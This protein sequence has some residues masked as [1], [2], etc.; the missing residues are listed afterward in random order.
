MNKEQHLLACL[1]EECAEIIKEVNKS[2]R[3]GIDD[4]NPNDPTKVTTRT[5]L[6]NELHELLAVIQL[7]TDHGTIGA[8]SADSDQIIKK[9]LKVIKYMDYAKLKGTLE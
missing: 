3:F 2:F 4:H 8:I 5:K 6:E 7:L 1:A 9:Q